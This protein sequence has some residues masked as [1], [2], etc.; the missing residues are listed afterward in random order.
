MTLD[1]LAGF[2]DWE[3]DRNPHTGVPRSVYG[4]PL[5]TIGPTLA[6]PHAEKPHRN[7]FPTCTYLLTI[8]YL[9]QCMDYD[10]SDLTGNHGNELYRRSP[11]EPQETHHR[12]GATFTPNMTGKIQFS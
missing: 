10:A 11:G 4:Y 5:P 12:Q 1:W 2:P 8:R 7:F 6:F 9:S 3:D